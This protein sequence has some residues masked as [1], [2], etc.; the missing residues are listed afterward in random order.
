MKSVYIVLKKR[1]NIIEKIH[2]VWEGEDKKLA[3]MLC[4]ELNS[5][6]DELYIEYVVHEKVIANSR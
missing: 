5:E 4:D 1:N 6:K 3:Q 2:S